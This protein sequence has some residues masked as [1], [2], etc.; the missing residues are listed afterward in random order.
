MYRRV[1]ISLVVALGA[2]VLAAVPAAAHVKVDPSDATQGSYTVLTFRVPNEEPDADTVGL[3][4]QLPVDHPLASVSVQPKPGWKYEVKRSKLAKPLQSDDGSVEEAD[5]EIDWTG[6]KIGP[7]EFDTF[8]I[9]VGPL[10]T[11][12]DQL[13]FKII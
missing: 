11:D 12:T 13:V 7:G 9:S 4:L 8:S 5:S 3:R 6:G 1:V 10:P 2:L